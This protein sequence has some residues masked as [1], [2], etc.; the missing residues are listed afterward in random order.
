MI[1]P[2]DRTMRSLSIRALQ[3]VVTAL[4]LAA[5]AACRHQNTSQ[6]VSAG[7]HPPDITKR[8]VAQFNAPVY[9]ASGVTQLLD[10]RILVAEDEERHPL[11]IIDLFGSGAAHD[12]SEREIGRQLADEHIKALNDLEGVTIDPRGFVYACT[13]HALTTKGES[14][15]ER[16]VLARFT[17]SGDRIENM[18]LAHGL[19]N[20]L[21]A[22][23]QI[24]VAAGESL[25]DEKRGLNIEGLAWDPQ[26][27]RLLIGFRNP[28]HKHKALAVWLGNPDDVFEHAAAPVLDGP[29]PLDLGGEGVRDLTFSPSLGGFVILAGAWKHDQHTAPTLWLWNGSTLVPPVRLQTDALTDLK[30]EGVVEVAVR[31]SHGLLIVSDDGS[32]DAEYDRQRSLQNRGVSSRYAVVPFTDLRSTNPTLK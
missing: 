12:Y 32:A 22:L 13:S 6:A 25:P 14:K 10:G 16:E 1:R 21:A 23:D 20:A 15:P 29:L 2:R 26:R 11:D 18:R 17:V 5:S 30:P 8:S 9:G 19:K 4:L 31:G 24:F 27:N 28:R 3:L 7:Y